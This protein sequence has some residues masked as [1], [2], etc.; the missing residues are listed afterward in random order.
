MGESGSEIEKG[1]R[2]GMMAGRISTVLKPELRD[3][4]LALR[5]EGLAWREKSGDRDTWVA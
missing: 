4:G 2:C 5:G 3:P 1:S